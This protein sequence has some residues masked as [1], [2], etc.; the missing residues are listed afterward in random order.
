MTKLNDQSK[1]IFKMNA[2]ERKTELKTPIQR[3]G[4]LVNACD[5][6]GWENT[7]YEDFKNLKSLVA[8]IKSE[9]KERFFNLVIE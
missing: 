9:N 5:K 8:E 7:T 1:I 6:I 4:E 3:L 2:Y